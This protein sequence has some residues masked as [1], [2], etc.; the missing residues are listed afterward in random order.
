MDLESTMSFLITEKLPSIMVVL[1]ARLTNYQ[2]FQ[3]IF[4]L[5]TAMDRKR[6]LGEHVSDEPWQRQS[7]N[8]WTAG[9][10]YFPKE[11]LPKSHFTVLANAGPWEP[12]WGTYSVG[13][14]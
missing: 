5:L 2:S 1:W 12:A 3:V 11:I 8:A 4:I 13:T 10:W 14:P 7:G 9:E 6:L